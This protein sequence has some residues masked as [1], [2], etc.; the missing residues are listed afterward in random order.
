MSDEFKRMD[1]VVNSRWFIPILIFVFTVSLGH[2]IGGYLDRITECECS[3][4][5]NDM[6]KD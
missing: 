6:N 5:A 3:C 4:A 2:V 1:N